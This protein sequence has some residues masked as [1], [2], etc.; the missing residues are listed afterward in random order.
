MQIL[1]KIKE[2]FKEK[3]ENVYVHNERRVYIDLKDK[4]DIEKFAKFMFYDLKMRFNIASGVDTRRGF[5]I[6]YH[7]SDDSSGR[8]I[9]LRAKIDDK[10]KPEIVS[11]TS[12][13]KAAGWIEREI[14]ELLGINFIGHPNLKRLLLS[15]D[16]PA[17]QYPLR[18]KEKDGE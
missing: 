15:E 3:I 9:S 4:N 12:V 8:I 17:C 7:F 10:D 18:H 14:H 11:I 13:F 2:T 16:W 6:L 5:E 1:E